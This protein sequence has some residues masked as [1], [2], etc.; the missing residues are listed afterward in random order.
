MKYNS[1]KLKQIRHLIR[2]NQLNL[3]EKEIDEYRKEYPKDRELKYYE[4]LLL[5]EKSKRDV[6]S[7]KDLLEKAFDLFSEVYDEKGIKCYEALYEMGRIH[8][9]LN[10]FDCAIACFTRVINES[11]YDEIFAAVELSKLY[12]RL[13][14]IAKAKKVLKDADSPTNSNNKY[15]LL[16]LANLELQTKNRGEAK[17]L[18]RCLPRDHSDFYRKVLCLKGKIAREEKLYKE[19][20]EYLDEGQG[21]KKDSIYY[22]CLFEKV[23]VYIK[24]NHPE[25]ALNLALR[26]KNNRKYF[27]GD[28]TLLLGNIYEQLGKKEE[29]RKYYQEIIME[30]KSIIHT[31]EAK[32]NLGLLAMKEHN[33]EEAKRWLQQVA[34]EKILLS[35]IAYLNLTFIAVREEEYDT[36]YDIIEKVSNMEINEQLE[37]TLE[38][39]KLYADVKTGKKIT[40]Q[41]RIY[42][43]EQI[44]SYSEEKAIEHIQE[45]HMS[46][47]KSVIFSDSKNIEGLFYQAKVAITGLTPNINCLADEYFL[48]I[49]KVGMINNILTDYL[50]VVCLPN[51]HDI[52]TMY[53]AIIGSEE[54]EKKE[55]IEKKPKHKV[56]RR[57]S[58]IEKFNARYNSNQ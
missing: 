58:Q 49:P 27:S 26:I 15:I 54:Q 53:P 42:S 50:K 23:K 52:I 41:E 8:N 19:A 36:C 13:G 57:L 10:D 40:N 34:T 1:G 32:L 33:L 47:D 11:P 7:S 43:E 45:S 38:K 22:S 29:A 14:Q 31:N 51:T 4:A 18:V 21:T 6:A 48:S 2:K 56:R 28:I 24:Q 44:I 3:A 25:E 9:I 16:A 30:E 5:K 46:G 20:L 39:L 35:T 55:I 12:E 37:K 17:R